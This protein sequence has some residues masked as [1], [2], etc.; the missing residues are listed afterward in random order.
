MV[1][2]TAAAGGVDA[3]GKVAR[4][5]EAL[6]ANQRGCA[7]RVDRVGGRTGS[8]AE[9]DLPQFRVGDAG[10]HVVGVADDAVRVA[11]EHRR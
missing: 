7:L 2:L 4:D 5:G 11:A 8:R 10:T 6:H 9:E 1:L 3:C